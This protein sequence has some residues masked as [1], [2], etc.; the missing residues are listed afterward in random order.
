[1]VWRQIA[2]LSFSVVV[3]VSVPFYYNLRQWF[4]MNKKIEEINHKT[5]LVKSRANVD[6]LNFCF[7]FIE[8]TP[9][10]NYVEVREFE[11]IPSDCSSVGGF[12]CHT[13]VYDF[14]P[15]V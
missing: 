1:M 10:I 13:Y 8:P 4:E 14:K 5:T 12:I 2:S 6:L 3:Y 15:S 11:Q 9:F 7:L